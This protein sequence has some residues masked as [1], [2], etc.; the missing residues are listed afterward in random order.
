MLIIGNGRLIT[1]DDAAPFFENGA[2]VIDGDEIKEAGN[3]A[4]LSEK[5]PGAEFLDAR[6]GVIMPGLI[7]T[8]THIY[9]ALA[10]GLSIRGYSPKNFREVLQGMWWRL[11]RRLTAEGTRASAY[12]TLIDCVKQGVTTIFDHHAG[13]CRIPGSLLTIAGA[14]LDT[15]VRCSLCYEVSDRD[16]EEKCLEAISENSDFYEH[17]Q[18]EDSGMLASMFG[19]HALFT[20]SDR[21]L[22]RVASAC[23]GRMGFHIHVSESMDDVADALKNYG[24]RPVNRLRDW[25]MLGEKTILAHC[26]HVDEAEMEI[27]RESGSIV[28]NNPESNMSNAVGCPPLLRFT[29]L[30]ILTGLGTDA[31]TND[32][33]ES[34]KAALC[35]QRHNAGLPNAAFSEVASMLFKSNPAIA[36]RFFKKPPG[37]L[38]P[39]AAAD[40]IVMDYRPFTPFD[41]ENADGHM[42]FGMSGR[43]CQTT[44]INGRVL[45][46][47][48]ELLHVDEAA[49]AAKALEASEK[50]WSSM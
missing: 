19:M 24:K 12:M 32:M 30:G 14:A 26:V 44:V 50:L 28:V 6:G 29:D 7:N 20:L 4:E 31:Y 35:I 49:H 10:R 8:H 40:V 18:K 21:T 5:Y 1:R 15:G 11:D 46:K 17:V 37:V 38:K 23:G 13:Y 3:G 16:G 36:A 25:G 27:I 42:L 41:A 39:G 34:A 9:S 45:M 47:D 48:R 43:Q 33:I 22:E 2:V